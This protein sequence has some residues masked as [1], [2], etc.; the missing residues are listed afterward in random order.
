MDDF[1]LLSLK[2][3]LIALGYGGPIF[4]PKSLADPG[5]FGTPGMASA[6]YGGLLISAI[7]YKEMFRCRIPLKFPVPH[8]HYRTMARN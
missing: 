7:S 5:L 3:G 2:S 8:P 6:W 4:A 1:I